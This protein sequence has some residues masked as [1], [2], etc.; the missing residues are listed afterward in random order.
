MTTFPL[1]P[2]LQDIPRLASQRFADRLQGGEP[3]RFCFAVFQDGDVGHGD[4]DFVGELGDAHFSLRQH[5]VDVNDDGHVGLVRPLSR[6]R[7]SGPR[8]FAAFFQT[9]P[10]LWRSRWRRRSGRDRSQRRL[11]CHPRGSE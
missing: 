2:I 1:L 5:D 4:A 8:H 7:T 6:S 3:D 11:Q 9:R 10:R